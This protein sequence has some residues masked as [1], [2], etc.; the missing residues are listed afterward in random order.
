M[1]FLKPSKPEE[2]RAK[3]IKRIISGAVLVMTMMLL[4]VTLGLAQ[5]A[6][7]GVKKGPIAMTNP[8]SGAEMFD[9]YCAVCHGKGAKGDG[10]LASELKIPPANLT[11][12]AR[13]HN[14]KYPSDYVAEVIR[15]GPRDAKSHGSKDMPVW[16]SVFKSIGDDA[17]VRQRIFNLNKYIES[18]QAR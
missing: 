6:T 14:G 13:N 9:T 7:P 15:S 8:S 4:S 11:L 3:M 12:L 18:L 17:S 16:G 2:W 1:L 5:E 10:P